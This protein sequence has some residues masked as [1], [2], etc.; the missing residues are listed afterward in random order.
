MEEQGDVRPL[1]DNGDLRLREWLVGV[2]V[3]DSCCG[4]DNA[5][6]LSLEGLLRWLTGRRKFEL[7]TSIN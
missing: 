7:V 4:G 3:G 6:M 1:T 2:A 5:P